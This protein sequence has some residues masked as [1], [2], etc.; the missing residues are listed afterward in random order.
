[1]PDWKVPEFTEGFQ[2]LRLQQEDGPLKK[3]LEFVFGLK[4]AITNFDSA[5]FAFFRKFVG[6]TF[7][8][9]EHNWGPKKWSI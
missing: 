9:R 6:S 2:A 5:C 8:V 3:R 7:A 1:M 4:E